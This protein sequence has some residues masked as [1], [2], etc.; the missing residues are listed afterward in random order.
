MAAWERVEGTPVDLPVVA[1]ATEADGGW[2][3][4][5]DLR[6]QESLSGAPFMDRRCGGADARNV[7]VYG[8]RMTY[9]DAMFSCLQGAYDQAGAAAR[10]LGGRAA[11]RRGRQ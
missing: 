4:R 7:V 9:S 2:L 3:L 1:T 6:G 8:H 10:A 11:R 5:H